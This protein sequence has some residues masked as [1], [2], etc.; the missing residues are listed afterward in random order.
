M[1][2]T[3]YS[4]RVIYNPKT[5]ETAIYQWDVMWDKV[6]HWCFWNGKKIKTYKGKLK[7]PKG[8]IEVAWFNEGDL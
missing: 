3:I 1:R 2:K 5:D 6:V 7:Y 8:F 4:P